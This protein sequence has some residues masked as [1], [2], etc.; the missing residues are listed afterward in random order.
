VFQEE[1]DFLVFFYIFHYN[2]LRPR[3]LLEVLTFSSF[4]YFDCSHEFTVGIT[5]GGRREEAGKPEY[6]NQKWALIK[7]KWPLN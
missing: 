4:N 3:E 1:F 2:W 5:I 6:F 7:I